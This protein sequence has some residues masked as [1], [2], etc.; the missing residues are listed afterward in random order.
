MAIENTVRTSGDEAPGWEDDERQRVL[1]LLGTV[2][3]GGESAASGTRSLRG[4]GPRASRAAGTNRGMVDSLVALRLRRSVIDS[5][6][7][8]IHDGV[9]ECEHDPPPGAG[10]RRAE[11]EARQLRATCEAIADGEKVTRTARAELVRAN[12]RLVVSIAKKHARRGLMFIDLI[13]EGNIGLMRAAEKF[14]YRLGYRFSTYATWWVRQAVTR[15][16]ADQA[17]TIRT[18]VHMFDLIG[19]V[20]R[21]S[22]LFAQEFGREP[23]TGELAAKLEVTVAKVV[24]AQGL[25]RQPV[26]LETPVGSEEGARVGDFLVDRSESALDAMMN[27]QRTDDTTQ[28]LRG[29][30]SR[31]AE[32]LRLRYGL[33][34]GGERT[35]AEIG[36]R[37]SVSRERIRQIENEALRRIR[38]RPETRACRAFLES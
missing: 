11:R 32:V 19:R 37:F 33:D 13:Q 31:E 21:A 29:L 9:A 2:L 5:A 20:T 36:I 22:R 1:R 34:G 28:L 12:L 35:L 30:T 15:A 3:G 17:T 27:A 38:R 7:R 8:R 23:T 4:N 6:V 10:K 25:V 16:I 24:A 18:P 26:S 14:E